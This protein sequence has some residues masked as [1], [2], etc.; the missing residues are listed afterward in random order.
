MRTFVIGL[1]L[2][3]GAAI[4]TPQGERAGEIKPNAFGNY[5]LYHTKGNRLG[6]GRES[7]INGTIR[8]YDP[9]GQPTFEVKP[10]LGGQLPSVPARPR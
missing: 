9:N 7:P 10:G 2:A 5:E 4:L 6:T 3:V 1:L 8:F